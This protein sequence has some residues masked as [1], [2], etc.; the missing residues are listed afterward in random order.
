MFPTVFFK[1]KGYSFC[2]SKLTGLQTTGISY[3]KAAIDVAEGA[4]RSRGLVWFFSHMPHVSPA[5]VFSAL[6]TSLASPV[7]PPW[8]LADRPDL[9]ANLLPDFAPG[10]GIGNCAQLRWWGG[11]G[12]RSITG[13][14]HAPCSHSAMEDLITDIIAKAVMPWDAR[15]CAKSVAKKAVRALF[16]PEAEHFAWGVRTTNFIAPLLAVLTCNIQAED[17]DFSE[18]GKQTARNPR[19]LDPY[20]VAILLAWGF[21]F[22]AKSHPPSML[23]NLE[24]AAKRTE[25]R[26]HLLRCSPVCNVAVKD[27]YLVGALPYESSTQTQWVDDTTTLTYRSACAAI[28]MFIS[29]LDSLQKDFFT[30]PI[31]AMASDLPV[32]VSDCDGYNETE[33]DG[34]T[35]FRIPCW[36]PPQNLG[37]ALA[38]TFN[39][40]TIRHDRYTGF[41][42]FGGSPSQPALI[43]CWSN[44]I[45]SP[46]KR[47][48]MGST[49]LRRAHK[50]YDLKVVIAEYFALLASLEEL[51]QN[52]IKDLHSALLNALI[53]NFQR[54]GPYRFLSGFPTCPINAQKWPS[55]LRDLTEA[56]LGRRLLKIFA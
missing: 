32:I 55:L 35:G 27:A 37:V 1:P 7:K 13:I 6:V 5:K 33:S 49:G 16:E 50:I 46:A 23:V 11:I 29:L 22:H 38:S 34:E 24:A 3:L 52:G 44:P 14:T 2:C 8:I 10:S 43:G 40:D 9:L 25:K 45:N 4:A 39:S 36:I 30:T 51:R 28:D 19:H 48:E 15:I 21:S 42:C 26:V 17:L 18:Q 56:V 20:E 53:C 12:E 47:A 41:A 54:Q 31:E